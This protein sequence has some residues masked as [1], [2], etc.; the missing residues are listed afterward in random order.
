MIS[1]CTVREAGNTIGS[2]EKTIDLYLSRIPRHLQVVIGMRVG[3]L[4]R[5]A[6]SVLGFS[7]SILEIFLQGFFD[8]I[9]EQ[10]ATSWA[11]EH[12]KRK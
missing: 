4:F 8:Y 3:K 6:F 7:D 11:Q 5:S 9:Q 1:N 2:W 10:I 12:H